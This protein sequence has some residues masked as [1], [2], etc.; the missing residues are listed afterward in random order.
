VLPTPT[1][2]EALLADPRGW[3]PAYLGPS[4]W[5]GLDLGDDPDWTEVRELVEES[6][7]LTAPAR[8]ARALDDPGR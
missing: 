7:R 1:E 5:L 4:G 3:V 6:F 2:R 8:L